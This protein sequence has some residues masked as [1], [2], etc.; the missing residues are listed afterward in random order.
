MRIHIIPVIILFLLISSVNSFAQVDVYDMKRIA[1]AKELYH[2][3]D[4]TMIQVVNKIK[5]QAEE[6]LSIPNLSVTDKKAVAPSLNIRDF[7]T[8]SPYF[9]PNPDTPDG[10]PYIHK[11]GETNPEVYDYSDRVEA[12]QMSYAA[13]ILGAAYY[14]TGDTRFAQK[15]AE[16]IRTWFL[17][18]KLGMNP[19]MKY[20][21]M[22]KGHEGVR[23]G[24]II[25]SRRFLYAFGAL[26]YIRGSSYWTAIDEKE[27]RDWS[28]AYCYWLDNSTNGRKENQ[29][30]NNHGL[31]YET[32]RLFL[33]SQFASPE[34]IRKSVYERMIPR[35]TSQI[36]PDGS[37][38][39]ELARTKALHYFTFALEGI[40][41]YDRI[42]TNVGVSLW[43]CDL[44][45]G[46]TLSK[47]MDYITPYYLNPQSWPFQ[48]IEPFDSRR[49]AAVLHEAGYKLRRDDLIKA[50]D[51]VGYIMGDLDFNTLLYYHCHY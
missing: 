26:S 48:Q 12:K 2:S 29:A 27:L 46:T 43:S 31:W 25:D 7:A 36:M 4:T 3:G 5:S 16:L 37:L 38:P 33:M 1:K 44:G 50:A 34:E 19:H 18:L 17:D 49:A 40:I 41:A 20:A 14:F 42:A 23:G 51:K 24:G 8:L 10:L 11:D 22:I 13:Q 30:K 15:S 39:R 35:L 32:F 28:R 9:W 47:V 45:G 21:Q 6:F